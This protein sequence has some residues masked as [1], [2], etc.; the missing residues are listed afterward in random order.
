VGVSSLDALARSVSSKKKDIC[1]LLDARRNLFYGCYY[2]HNNGKIQRK[3]DY[4][5]AP[6]AEILKQFSSDVIVIGDGIMLAKDAIKKHPSKVTFAPANSWR[7]QA[8][9]LLALG[10]ARLKK[11]DADRVDALTP[12]Y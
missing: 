9:Y 6:L 4:L 7:A 5:L 3:S 12:I 11:K 8:K 1:V 2:S 10:A